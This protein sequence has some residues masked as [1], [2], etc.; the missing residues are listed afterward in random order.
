MTPSAMLA[1]NVLA[2]YPTI[3]LHHLHGQQQR[4]RHLFRSHQHFL[5]CDA[6]KAQTAAHL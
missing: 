3:P 1:N 5:L 4:E 2:R 6:E